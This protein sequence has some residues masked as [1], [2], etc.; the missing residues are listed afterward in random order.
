MRWSSSPRGCLRNANNGVSSPPQSGNLLLSTP[1]KVSFEESSRSDSDSSLESELQH[2]NSSCDSVANHPLRRK[3]SLLAR[4]A[5]S[6]SLVDLEKQCQIEEMKLPS[7]SLEAAVSEEE[8]DD[9]EPKAKRIC[10]PRPSPRTVK[11][12]EDP[13]K[14]WGQFVD[15][16]IPEDE[17]RSS[18]SHLC[19]M[20]QAPSNQCCR[21]SSCRLRRSSPYGDYKNSSRTRKAL[22]PPSSLHL[23]TSTFTNPS[24]SNFRLAPKKAHSQNAQD[25]LIGAFSG[26]N[27]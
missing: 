17:A 10:S 3:R 24:K 26:L 12:T 11:A 23:Q 20:D 7:S 22:A 8:E 15:M 16:L 21:E 25:Q 2:I 18:S 5:T 9:G 13:P 4:P 14:T 19:Y 6:M 1:R 27:F